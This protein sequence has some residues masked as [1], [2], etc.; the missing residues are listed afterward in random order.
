MY[1]VSTII[2]KFIYALKYVVKIA[3][4]IYGLNPIQNRD[5]FRSTGIHILHTKLIEIWY[6]YVYPM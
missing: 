6:V 5:I 3:S 4:S 1:V 2:Y